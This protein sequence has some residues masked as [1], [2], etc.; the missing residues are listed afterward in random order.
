MLLCAVVGFC[1]IV[2]AAHIN[3]RFICEN[4]NREIVGRLQFYSDGTF[5]PWT[6]CKDAELVSSYDS[7]LLDTPQT[8]TYQAP[9][10]MTFT[11]N[12]IV[13]DNTVPEEL[14]VIRLEVSGI[15]K[16]MK[17]YPTNLYKCYTY[18][19]EEV[20]FTQF[21]LKVTYEDGSFKHKTLAD[22][23][24][25]AFGTMTTDRP[26]SYK[27]YTITFAYGD[28]TVDFKYDVLIKPE[29]EAKKGMLGTTFGG[30]H[31]A[32]AAALAVLE[33]MNSENLVQN[34]AEQGS[35]LMSELR[36]ES[37]IVDMRGRGL[38]IGI[39]LPMPQSDFRSV[40]LNEYHVLTGMAGTNTLR[41]LPAL[42]ITRE[43]CDRFLEAFHGTMKKF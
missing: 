3:K 1:F 11:I 20:D 35:Y 41:L 19:G 24:I 33:V 30:S 2:S 29:I 34:A 4:E 27:G 31:L 8:L 13:Y 7:Q 23:K 42:T 12:V 36:K 32:C 43:D 9:N 6:A 14:K 40:L 37:K 39:D 38:M 25:Q 16:A 5:S 17:Y 22:S 28:A 26:S 18:V 15:P 21:E 10:G